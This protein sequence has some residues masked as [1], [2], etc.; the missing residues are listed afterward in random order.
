[1]LGEKKGNGCPRGGFP[2]L[3]LQNTLRTIDKLGGCPWS[4]QQNLLE[5]VYSVRQEVVEHRE[6]GISQHGDFQSPVPAA[7]LAR[8]A[9]PGQGGHRWQEPRACVGHSGSGD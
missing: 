3:L 1:V 6:G 2:C 7:R 4:T 5:T 8:P 9:A